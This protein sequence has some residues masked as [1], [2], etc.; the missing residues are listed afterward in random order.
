MTIEKKTRSFKKCWA[1]GENPI[2]FSFHHLPLIK[3]ILNFKDS[4]LAI[5]AGVPVQKLKGAMRKAE[6]LSERTNQGLNGLLKE[7]YGTANICWIALHSWVIQEWGEARVISEGSEFSCSF[8]HT[9]AGFG[10]SCDSVEGFKAVSSSMNEP[11]PGGYGFN[12]LNKFLDILDQMTELPKTEWVAFWQQTHQET[13]VT[14]GAESTAAT[15]GSTAITPVHEPVSRHKEDVAKAVAAIEKEAHN[16][17]AD[18][19]YSVGV[20]LAKGLGSEKPDLQNAAYWLALAA[21][22]GHFQASKLLVRVKK[23][24]QMHP[25]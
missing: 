1:V 25:R 3:R 14:A 10:I 21:A 17:D 13:A 22:D 9:E 19:K 12:R 5:V 24:L 7:S 2:V 15:V 8:V 6:V 18:A 16:G 20:A 11:L 23:Q 4:E